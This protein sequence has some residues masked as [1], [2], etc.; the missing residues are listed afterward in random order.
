MMARSDWA[1]LASRDYVD[2]ACPLD[3]LEQD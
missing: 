3:G 1:G 2:Q